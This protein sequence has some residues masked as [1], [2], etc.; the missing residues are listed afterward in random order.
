MNRVLY[1]K[2]SAHL[3]STFNTLFIEKNADLWIFLALMLWCFSLDLT[4]NESLQKLDN[5][6]ISYLLKHKF[7]G[8]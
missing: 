6:S 1:N 4:V 2:R 8:T 5:P 3:E 7:H